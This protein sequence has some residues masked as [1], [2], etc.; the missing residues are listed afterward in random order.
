MFFGEK[1]LANTYVRPISNDFGT[2]LWGNMP[3]SNSQGIINFKFRLTLDINPINFSN[4]D[5][6]KQEAQSSNET[7][8]LV[9]CDYYDG[10]TITTPSAGWNASI[11]A[12]QKDLAITSFAAFPILDPA[13]VEMERIIQS[14][15]KGPWQR[16]LKR[17]YWAP[18]DYNTI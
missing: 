5:L 10:T 4:W 18:P 16:Q 3:I 8:Y 13:L 1:I 11:S 7:K 2:P 15:T 14:N 17:A 12:I 6:L 9:A